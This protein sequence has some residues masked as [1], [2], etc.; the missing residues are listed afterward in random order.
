M[1]IPKQMK[2]LCPKFGRAKNSL[3]FGSISIHVEIHK[4]PSAST[5]Q[6]ILLGLNQTIENLSAQ[7]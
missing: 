4:F 1:Q 2:L 5:E 3:L 7:M 6:I